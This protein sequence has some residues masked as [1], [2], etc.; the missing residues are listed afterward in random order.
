MKTH[1]SLGEDFVLFQIALEEDFTLG[2]IDF[3][4]FPQSEIDFLDFPQSEIDF[5]DFPVGALFSNRNC[6][7]GV[8]CSGKDCPFPKS[9]SG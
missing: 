2:S 1:I 6:P 7:G 8:L 4:D 9:S 5:L 3:L